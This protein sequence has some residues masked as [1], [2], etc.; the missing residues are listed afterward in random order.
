MIAE[1]QELH[2]RIQI[3]LFIIIYGLTI[4]FIFLIYG[5]SWKLLFYNIQCG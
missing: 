5:F 3:I 2:A 1:G 4:F